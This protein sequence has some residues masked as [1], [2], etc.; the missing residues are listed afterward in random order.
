ML[1]E[2]LRSAVSPLWFTNFTLP[3]A[4]Q[5]ICMLPGLMNV[6]ATAEPRNMANHIKTSLV[7]S[8]ELRKKC[9]F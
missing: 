6:A 1:A 9:M 2:A 4:V 5:T 7:M 3:P 8:V